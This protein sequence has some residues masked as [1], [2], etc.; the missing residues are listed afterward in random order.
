M[1]VG[2]RGTLLGC[3]E[4]QE[5]EAGLRGS[6]ARPMRATGT[7]G[8]KKGRERDRGGPARGGNRGRPREGE[9]QAGE[10]HGLEARL[11]QFFFKFDFPNTFSNGF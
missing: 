8:G 10:N 2:L 7:K 1:G 9:D 6:R 4:E 11:A 3:A 5:E